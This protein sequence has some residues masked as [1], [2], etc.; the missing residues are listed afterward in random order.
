M[1]SYHAFKAG[2]IGPGASRTA[3]D[4]EAATL[5]ASSVGEADAVR[6]AILPTFR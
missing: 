2:V 5:Q 4:T 1:T 3:L 6:N